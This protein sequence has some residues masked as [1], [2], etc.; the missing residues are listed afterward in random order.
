MT[1]VLWIAHGTVKQN[2]SSSLPRRCEAL[3]QKPSSGCSGAGRDG[4]AGLTSCPAEGLWLLLWMLWWPHQWHLLRW[5]PSVPSAQHTEIVVTGW[6]SQA[7]SEHK[8]K[9]RCLGSDPGRR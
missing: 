8:P 1:Q 9:W 5:D 4:C 3:K 7:A 2:A 6:G